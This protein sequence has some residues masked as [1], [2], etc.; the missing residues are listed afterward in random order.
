MR[1]KNET[2]TMQILP[3]AI[4]GLSPTLSLN[5]KMSPYTNNMTAEYQASFN[6]T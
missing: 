2:K 4:K 5:L 6:S 3:L 1:P